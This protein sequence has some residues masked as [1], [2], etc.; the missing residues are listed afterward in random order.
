MKYRICLPLKGFLGTYVY[1]QG[2]LQARLATQRKSL[3]FLILQ[4]TKVNSSKFQ[5][6]SSGSSLPMAACIAASQ[7]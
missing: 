2:N 4:A 5:T 7:L 3:H 1:K 6:S